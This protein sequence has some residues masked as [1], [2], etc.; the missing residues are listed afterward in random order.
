MAAKSRNKAS[1]SRLSGRRK[2]KT[3]GLK[4]GVEVVRPCAGFGGLP[5]KPSE[6]AFSV[7]ATKPSSKAQHDGDGIRAC[8]EASKRR[9]RGVIAVLASGGREARWMRGHPMSKIM[10]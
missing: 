9:T 8:R 6:E 7:W 1:S 2:R 4:L 3:C 5:T 10:Y